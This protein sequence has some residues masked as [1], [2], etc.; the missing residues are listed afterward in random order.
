MAQTLPPKDV[1]V[2]KLNEPRSPGY[3][4]S[5]FYRWIWSAE[6]YLALAGRA[7]FG[8]YST[9]TFDVWV[10]NGGVPLQVIDTFGNFVGPGPG[11]G[12]GVQLQ[13]DPPT[14]E[15]HGA[16]WV[17]RVGRVGGLLASLVT[18]VTDVQVLDGV[19]DLALKIF[20]TGEIEFSGKSAPDSFRNFEIGN[21]AS[22]ALHGSGHSNDLHFHSS[23][24]TETGFPPV[25]NE[26]RFHGHLF[27]EGPVFY[28][29]TMGGD[30]GVDRDF[31][32]DRYGNMGIPT[33]LIVAGTAN[34]SATDLSFAG[35][36]FGDAGAFTNQLSAWSETWINVLSG[37]SV[38]DLLGDRNEITPTSIT[39]LRPNSTPGPADRS[40]LLGT[41]TVRLLMEAVGGGP[42]LGE[43][44]LDANTTWPARVYLNENGGAAWASF[45]ANQLLLNGA[46]Y[47]AEV[48]ALDAGHRIKLAN[49]AGD[50]WGAFDFNV[51]G[52]PIFGLMKGILT[53]EAEVGYS[54]EDVTILQSRNTSTG[55]VAWTLFD[56]FDSG[57]SLTCRTVDTV[58]TGIFAG[59][60][61][62]LQDTTPGATQAG[63]SSDG[64]SAW[65]GTENAVLGYN[66]TGVGVH[67]TDSAGSL[68]NSHV[69]HDQLLVKMGGTGDVP[70]SSLT[71]GGFISRHYELG[72]LKHTVELVTG[73]PR[74]D[75]KDDENN[76]YARIEPNQFSTFDINT[77][78]NG[79]LTPTA[80][81]FDATQVVGS[82]LLGVPDATG[83]AVID[84]ECRAAVNALL[85]RVR[86][87]GLINP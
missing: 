60:L 57:G 65:K 16:F 48:N 63:G 68:P 23:F 55:L 64:W 51:D 12:S 36:A 31:T 66:G 39:L 46:N 25:W 50:A 84:V 5:G 44:R 52:N 43:V 87:H 22:S 79:A 56:A 9:H 21:N 40:L 7:A 62:S 35:S 6:E 71:L 42:A 24:W 33:S 18:G 15:Q 14:V 80:L 70:Y 8:W 38:G 75:V 28:L 34:L 17:D 77:A 20:D 78:H 49:G 76:I 37:M 30:L 86:T 54:G 41:D 45:T 47:S 74:F 53:I 29:R 73:A 59:W 13:A 58:K 27:S 83:G 3:G 19:G 72:V 2:T 85:A 26:Y 67:V 69:Y 81:K 11:P 32:F 1:Y 10:A 82:R 4:T 61:V